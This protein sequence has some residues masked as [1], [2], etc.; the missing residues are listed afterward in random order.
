MGM[1]RA[2]LEQWKYNDV[3]HSSVTIAA[4]SFQINTTFQFLVQVVH[5][6]NFT[7]RSAGYLLVKIEHIQSPIIT[8]RFVEVLSQSIFSNNQSSCVIAMMCSS[9][10]RSYYINPT[11]QLA[12]F[13]LCSGD[14]CLSIEK[15][16]WNVYRESINSP[17]SSDFFYGK[18][19]FD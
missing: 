18:L 8:I 15:I 3:I 4:E 11:T 5:R 7:R 13:S 14:D 12:L 19:P 2:S 6:Y 17:I 10:D 1:N 16:Q 9:T